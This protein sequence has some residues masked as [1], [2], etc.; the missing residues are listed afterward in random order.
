MVGGN[1]TKPKSLWTLMEKLPKGVII[2][3]VDE[4]RIP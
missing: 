2:T 1:D 4:T 3:V